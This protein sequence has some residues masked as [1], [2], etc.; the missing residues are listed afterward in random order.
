MGSEVWRDAGGVERGVCR[1][2]GLDKAWLGG[3]LDVA[4]AL[5]NG[6][7]ERAYCNVVWV[8]YVC[9]VLVWKEEGTLRKC[10]DSHEKAMVHSGRFMI[11][12]ALS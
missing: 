7:D 9:V 5:I 10:W 3:G 2:I 11:S 12:L 8:L 1:D 6:S 4:G